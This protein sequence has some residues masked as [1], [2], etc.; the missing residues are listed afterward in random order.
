MLEVLN[1]FFFIRNELFR[2]RTGILR[3]KSSWILLQ[4]PLLNKAD[5]VILFLFLAYIKEWLEEC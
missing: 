5:C 1:R 3:F 2:S 4:I